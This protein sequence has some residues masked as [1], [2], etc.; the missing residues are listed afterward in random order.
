[1]SWRYIIEA[2]RTRQERL[3][4]CSHCHSVGVDCPQEE[5]PERRKEGFYGEGLCHGLEDVHA[6]SDRRFPD[7]VGF[8]EIL[9]NPVSFGFC[10]NNGI[11]KRNDRERSRV[12]L[13]N[14]SFALLR[15]HLPGN[16]WKGFGSK[17]RKLT[18][19]RRPASP[20]NI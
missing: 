5:G 17:A 8:G 4:G 11:S 12:K 3:L 14:S 1:M 7:R 9:T 19:V 2:T 6:S 15:K 20:L 16:C 18:K 10:W 13:I